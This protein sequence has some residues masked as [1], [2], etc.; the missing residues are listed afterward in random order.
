MAEH[1]SQ[2]SLLKESSAERMQR[3]P[4]GL[5][6]LASLELMAELAAT[7]EGAFMFSAT[8]ASLVVQTV[9]RLSVLRLAVICQQA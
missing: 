5:V 3:W 8:V 6:S 9:S 4:L 7:T 1:G 2:V